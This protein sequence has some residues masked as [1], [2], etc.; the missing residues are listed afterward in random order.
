MDCNNCGAVIPPNEEETA[1]TCYS[2]QAVLE[3][4]EELDARETLADEDWDV[5]R[6]EGVEAHRLL[7]ETHGV[8]TPILP[9]FASEDE[10]RDSADR[11]PATRVNRGSRR[12]T[13]YEY[14][15]VTGN[16]GGKV[17]S[18]WVEASSDTSA[19]SKYCTYVSEQGWKLFT[20]AG[21]YEWP[22]DP[23]ERHPAKRSSL[24]VSTPTRDEPDRY[25]YRLTSKSPL[26]LGR[27]ERTE[28]E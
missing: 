6:R 15:Q 16:I 18:H 13:T 2:C 12:A 25:L 10:V 14:Y 19:R 11:H 22:E 28:G 9:I 17:T 1:G 5:R 23:R 4:P 24:D 3:H 27:R 8:T 20:R 21:R 26:V 7:I